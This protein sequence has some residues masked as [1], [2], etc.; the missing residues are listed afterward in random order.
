MMKSY[1]VYYPGDESI[2]QKILRLKQ[3]YTLCSVSLQDIIA[4]LEKIRSKCE[5]TGVL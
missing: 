5:L 2:E 4:C 3:Q 1:A